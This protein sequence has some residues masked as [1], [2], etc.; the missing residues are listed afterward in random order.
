MEDIN[1]LLDFIEN[2]IQ[3]KKTGIFSGIDKNAIINCIEKIRDCLPDVF[4]KK[5]IELQRKKANQ[6]IEEA[7]LRRQ[8]LVSETE[9]VKEATKQAEQI[10]KKAY[11]VQNEYATTTMQNL[12]KMLSDINEHL[13]VAQE[14]IKKAMQDLEK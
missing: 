7:E 3:A 5:N 12:Y 4:N 14:S 6:I 1:I 8:E 11:E 2:E 10:V 13:Q 9:I